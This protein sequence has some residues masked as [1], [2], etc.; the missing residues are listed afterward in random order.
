MGCTVGEGGSGAGVGVQAGD[1][2][3]HRSFFSI[4]DQAVGDVH[5]EV[6]AGV[7][8]GVEHG[9]C[10]GAGGVVAGIVG[11]GDGDR[12]R[13]VAQARQ[14]DTASA[15]A[16]AMGAVA[17]GGGGAGVGVQT[18]DGVSHGGFF[19]IVD[20]IVG[21]VH[22]QVVAGVG[23]GVELEGQRCGLAVGSGIGVGHAH[24][25]AAVG[26]SAGVVAADHIAVDLDHAHRIAVGSV[27]AQVRLIGQAVTG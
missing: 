3:G 9:G 26:Q 15:A 16:D 8:S 21:D 11:R 13:A 12:D 5:R 22:R 27:E 23:G 2:V 6:A 18:G 4:V 10:A 7:S 24:G 20:Q 19:S 1:G 14:V 17:E 25:V